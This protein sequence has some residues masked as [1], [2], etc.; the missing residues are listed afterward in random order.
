MKI[1]IIGSN[2]FIGKNLKINFNNQKKYKVFYFSSYKKFKDKWVN[3][4]CNEIKKNKP[5]IIINCAASQ[6]LNDDKKSIKKLLNSNLYSNI[7]FLNQ[8]TNYKN[9]KGYISFGTKWEFDTERKYKPLNFYAA[10]KNANDIL[11]KYFSLKKNVTTVSLKI[12][13]TYGLN[14]KR[15]K[16]LNLL[17][18]KY[19]KNQS[20]KITPGR[21]YL[22]FVHIHD[23]CELVNIICK[24]II[25]NKI[26]GFKYFTVS[27]KR[28]IKLKSLVNK[29]N[30]ILK[31]KLKVKIGAKKYRSNEAMKPIKKLYNYPGWK[32][33]LNLVKELKKIFDGTNDQM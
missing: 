9:F 6:V 28:P 4:I 27:S 14:D 1:G 19:K 31:K 13:D 22:D 15:N 29:M 12:F 23:I 24:D 25:N 11:F 5:N 8:A 26:K 33:K 3:K 7:M 17:L 18:R 20:L 2:G 16:V 30:L 32:P 10:T 21:Q